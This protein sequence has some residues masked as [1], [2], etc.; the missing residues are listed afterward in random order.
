MLDMPNFRPTYQ[1]TNLVR[2]TVN[3]TL[4]LIIQFYI[5]QVGHLSELVGH[6]DSSYEAFEARLAF[7]TGSDKLFWLVIIAG[8]RDYVITNF[9]F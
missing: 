2:G 1:T 5:H 6:V 4:L 3:R 7:I 9:K 8:I